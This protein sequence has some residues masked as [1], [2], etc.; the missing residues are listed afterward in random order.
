MRKL[1]SRFDFSLGEIGATHLRS[2]K[3]PA[4][5]VAVLFF[6]LVVASAVL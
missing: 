2:I 1:R 3:V 5:S 4:S 6:H